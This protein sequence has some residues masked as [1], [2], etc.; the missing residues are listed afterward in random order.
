M[1][2]IHEAYYSE[3]V[4]SA[5][6]ACDNSRIVA[7]LRSA[8]DSHCPHL[9]E[10]ARLTPELAEEIAGAVAEYVVSGFP[11]KTAGCPSKGELKLLVLHM[12]DLFASRRGGEA[13]KE[14][15]HGTV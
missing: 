5:L 11:D 7:A 8:H 1:D 13:G 14:G 10:V 2:W 9:A 6:F 4:Q 3:E 12:R 15:E